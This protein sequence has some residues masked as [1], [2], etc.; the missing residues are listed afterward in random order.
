ME[1]IEDLIEHPKT[2]VEKPKRRAYRKRSELVDADLGPDATINRI[3]V[4]LS[5]RMPKS[6]VAA[7]ESAAKSVNIDKS[8]WLRAAF[9]Y[10]LETKLT[11]CPKKFKGQPCNA[12]FMLRVNKDLRDEITRHAD[13]CGLKKSTW[14]KGA[15]E[16]CLADPDIK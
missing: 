12:T 16:Y 1:K 4:P 7:V 15:V 13:R 14:M 3:G 10:A 2:S 9:E 5:L 8:N 6:M 11:E